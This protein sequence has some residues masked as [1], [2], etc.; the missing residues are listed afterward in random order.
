MSAIPPQFSKIRKFIG[1]ITG[2]TQK[3][4]GEE[5]FAL[6]MLILADMLYGNVNFAL[7]KTKKGKV[8]GLN[9]WITANFWVSEAK[10]NIFIFLCY[11]LCFADIC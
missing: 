9:L 3:K 4:R 2:S 10:D 6:I 1:I 8:I 7:D 11:L 5:F